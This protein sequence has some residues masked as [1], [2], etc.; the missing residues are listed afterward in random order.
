M[1]NRIP[2]RKA[3][4]EKRT[5]LDLELIGRT[6]ISPTV[7]WYDKQKEEEEEKMIW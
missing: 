7:F 4:F 3:L 5:Y 2:T 6:C 1:K